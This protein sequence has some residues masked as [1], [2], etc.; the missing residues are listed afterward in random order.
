MNVFY[1]LLP[2]DLANIS[3]KEP[4][5]IVLRYTRGNKMNESFTGCIKM[6]LVSAK[7]IS[8][9]NLT[10]LSPIGIDF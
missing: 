1:L 5:S 2:M 3:G 8:T 6:S 9:A 4:L 7:S 10:Y